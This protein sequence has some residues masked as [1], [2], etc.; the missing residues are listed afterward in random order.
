[1]F[2]TPLVGAL[3]VRIEPRRLVAVGAALLAVSQLYMAGHLHLGVDFRTAL[4]MRIYQ[5]AGLAFLFVPINTLVYAGAPREKNNAI[6][7]IMNLGRNLGGSIGIAFVTT[8]IARQAQVHQVAL[9]HHTNRYDPAFTA[10]LDRVARSLERSGA[11]AVDAAHRALAVVYRELQAQATQLAYLDTLRLLAFVALA[12]LPLL[13]L[14][15]SPRR[16]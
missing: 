8:M 2:L 5:V 9:V 1:M 3:V 14:V 13:L 12:M 11:S 16:G 6:A 7:A 4:L 15:R 10:H